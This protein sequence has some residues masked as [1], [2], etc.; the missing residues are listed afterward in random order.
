[1]PNDPVR[2]ANTEPDPPIVETR[3]KRKLMGIPQMVESGVLPVGTV[4]TIRNELNSEATV[5]DGNT[6][7][8]R[9]E[10][11]PFN[12]WGL[13]VKGWKWI[14]IYVMAILPDGRPLG[15]LRKEI[16]DQRYD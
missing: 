10:Q 3:T 7:E 15:D 8:F 9:G 16:S 12:D 14:K 1:M 5:I 4:L 13:R 11:M 2:K 6:V